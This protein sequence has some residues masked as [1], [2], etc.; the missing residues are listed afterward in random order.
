MR[1]HDRAAADIGRCRSRAPATMAP[2][3]ASMAMIDWVCAGRVFHASAQM[4]AG[5]MAG[6]V[7]KH[8]D[9]FVRRLGVEQCAGIDENV[10]A[11]HH[12][13]IEG[14]VVEHDD[15]DVLLRKTGGLED[16]RC[17]IAH[18]LLDLGVADQRQ[19]ARR[20]SCARAGVIMGPPPAAT[21]TAMAVKSATA[22]AAGAARPA[23]IGVPQEPDL[24]M[25]PSD[26][27]ETSDGPWGGQRG[28]RSRLVHGKRKASEGGKQAGEYGNSGALAGLAGQIRC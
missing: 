26:W 22:R 2:T 16:R 14:A 12:K 24:I 5:Q 15:L 13:G 6:F 23:L 19:A 9:H 18:Q 17:V 10:A 1:R 21:A 28:L 11:V 20:L 8:A 3:P 25:L 7:R 27:R 4:S